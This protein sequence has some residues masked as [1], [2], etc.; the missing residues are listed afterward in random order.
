MLQ[1][2][3]FVYLDCPKKV[4]SLFK[5]IYDLK[6]L[7]GCGMGDIVF[8][9]YKVKSKSVLL[10]PTYVSKQFKSFCPFTFMQMIN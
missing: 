3:N 9:S 1:P 2:K 10:I 7:G 5:T 8:I 6:Q 4:Y